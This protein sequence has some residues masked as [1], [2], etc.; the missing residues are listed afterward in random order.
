MNA[1]ERLLEYLPLPQE[2]AAVV[3]DNRPPP[4]W[5]SRGRVA[6]RNLWLRYRPELDPVLRD[7]SFTLEP[8]ENLGVC[9]RTGS[10]KSSLMNAIY[11]IVEPYLGGIVID[12][13]D[14]LGVGLKDLRSKLSLVP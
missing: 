14:V 2:S 11:R 4:T 13:V 10:G 3:K 5:P 6:V 8:G 9:G 1:V 7:V 12:D